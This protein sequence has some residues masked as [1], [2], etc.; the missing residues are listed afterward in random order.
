MNQVQTANLVRARMDAKPD[1]I[2]DELEIDD[3]GDRLDFY[4]ELD[5]E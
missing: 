2:L 4:A 1:L 5:L 3:G